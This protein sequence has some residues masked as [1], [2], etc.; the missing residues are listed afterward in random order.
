MATEVTGDFWN[1]SDPKKPIGLFD[2]DAELDFPFISNYWVDADNKPID[3][4][5]TKC[6]VEGFGVFD[7]TIRGITKNVLIVR[8]KKTS[9]VA[10]KRKKLY[11]IELNFGVA[12]GQHDQKTFWL[13]LDER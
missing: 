5:S 12:D 13:M 10:I 9:G 11:P 6:F 1:V 8:I 4:D 2:P 7:C 3:L